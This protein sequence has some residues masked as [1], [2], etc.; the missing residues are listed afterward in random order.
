MLYLKDK[1]VTLHLRMSKSLLD[2]LTFHYINLKASTNS[3]I[4]FS[5]YIRKLLDTYEF[6][7]VKSSNTK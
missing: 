5:E 2:K 7:D 3:S 6:K 1:S 4:S